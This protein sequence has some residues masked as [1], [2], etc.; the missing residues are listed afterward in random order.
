MEKQPPGRKFTPRAISNIRRKLAAMEASQNASIS[1][2]SQYER[3]MAI[4]LEH[5]QVKLPQT[6]NTAESWL[7]L[8]PH[9]LRLVSVMLFF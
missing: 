8:L 4:F 5:S 6:S 1:A 3:I 9:P 2:E 7:R